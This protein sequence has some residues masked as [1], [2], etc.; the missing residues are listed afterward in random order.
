MLTWEA[1]AGREPRLLSLLEE[2]KRLNPEGADLETVYVQFKRPL[3]RVVGW[4]R[5]TSR[6]GPDWLFDTAAYEVALLK[7]RGALEMR[8]E[9]Q[10]GKEVFADLDKIDEVLVE[11]NAKP[12]PKTHKSWR[13]LRAKMQGA[14]EGKDAA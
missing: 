2:A 12:A 5:A 3:S 6:G 9:V 13:G 8:F 4:E 14:K 10:K 1:V 7:I 11:V